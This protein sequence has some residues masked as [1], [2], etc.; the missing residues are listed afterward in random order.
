VGSAALVASVVRVALDV[1]PRRPGRQPTESGREPIVPL[2][3]YAVAEVSEASDGLL[4]TNHQL[5]G[6]RLRGRS[7]L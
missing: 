6:D 5:R 7:T 3:G 2:T 1:T 4:L